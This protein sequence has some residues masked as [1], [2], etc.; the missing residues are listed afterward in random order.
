MER[1]RER[2]QQFHAKDAQGKTVVVVTVQ[3]EREEVG[4]NR[5]PIWVNHG[6]PTLK[7]VDGMIINYVRKGV[8]RT[9]SGVEY[10]S[11]DPN[12]P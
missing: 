7:M 12:A 4:W 6:K 9:V 5:D 8:Y 2:I 1:F 3:V 11:D 10:T